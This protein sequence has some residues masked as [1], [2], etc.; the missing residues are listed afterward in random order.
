MSDP[1]TI[2]D[3]SKEELLVIYRNQQFIIEDL[4]NKIKLLT[5]CSGF[6]DGDGTCGGCV[7]CYYDNQETWLRCSAFAD[8]LDRYRKE[9]LN[10]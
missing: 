1:K 5:G 3:L 10:G 4:K 9:L 6:G 7:E 2:E 8:A